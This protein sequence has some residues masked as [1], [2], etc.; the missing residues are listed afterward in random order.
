MTRFELFTSGRSF[1]VDAERVGEEIHAKIDGELFKVRLERGSEPDIL[2]ALVNG[3]FASVRIEEQTDSS[4][5]LRVRDER[6]A[7]HRSM[8]KLEQVRRT[9]RQT[10]E[11]K[12]SLTSPM[13]GRVVSV[14][15]RKGQSVRAGD[16][17]LIME[18]MKMETILMSD[19]DALVGEVLVTE[20]E[21][22]RMGQVLVR[23]ARAT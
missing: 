19:R 15:V 10:S 1:F 5:V 2:L 11:H 23:Y 13:P 16:P 8:P 18:S 17:L 20:G 7:F 14:I 9:P 4:L 21:A 12:D 22:V 6:L 3:R